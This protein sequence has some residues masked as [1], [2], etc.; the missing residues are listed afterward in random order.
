[1]FPQTG[2]ET[3][4]PLANAEKVGLGVGRRS[5]GRII[6]NPPP[7]FPRVLR[8]NGRLYCTLRELD[9]H[10]ARLIAGSGAEFTDI[11]AKARSTALALVRSSATRAITGPTTGADEGLN[12][13]AADEGDQGRA[14]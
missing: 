1:M 10:K 12:E 3:L 7:G 11:G 6:K 13:G 5:I 2:S 4:V 9:A 8:I 14:E